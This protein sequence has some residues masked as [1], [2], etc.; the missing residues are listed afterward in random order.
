MHDLEVVVEIAKAAQQHLRV[1]LDLLARQR[2]FIV[3][4]LRVER[5]WHVVEDECYSTQV[6][7]HVKERNYLKIIN[8]I[9]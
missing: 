8:E 4:Q 3:F 9:S 2:I 1:R 7:V 5:V 6:G